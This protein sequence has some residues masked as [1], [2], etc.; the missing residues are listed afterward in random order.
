MRPTP[1]IQI[2][3]GAAVPR[4]TLPDFS[5]EAVTLIKPNGGINAATFYNLFESALLEG[6]YFIVPTNLLNRHLQ[7][8]IAVI[9][10]PL[11]DKAA[12]SPKEGPFME[13]F[14]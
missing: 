13:H 1:L 11:K 7:S 2:L 14:G 4:L 12:P 8:T 6:L 5:A 10:R 3:S 9:Y